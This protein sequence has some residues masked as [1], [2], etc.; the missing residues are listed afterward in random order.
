M[1]SQ[2]TENAIAQVERRRKATSQAT[3]SLGCHQLN[4]RHCSKWEEPPK[5]RNS[6]V[7]FF[8]CTTGGEEQESCLLELLPEHGM[9]DLKLRMP[10]DKESRRSV[11]FGATI[12]TTEIRSEAFVDQIQHLWHSSEELAQIENMNMAT[13]RLIKIGEQ[14]SPED[15]EHCK[16]GLESFLSTKSLAATEATVNEVLDRQIELWS[17]GITGDQSRLLSKTYCLHSCHHVFNA[18]VQGLNDW[19]AVKGSSPSPTSVFHEIYRISAAA[20]GSPA[21]IERQYHLGSS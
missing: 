10:L 8:G 7:R 19:L 21:V 15:M 1:F 14:F 16:R 6:C 3:P 20:V 9:F 17:A 13:V 2:Q 12:V 4:K 5:R 11:T 18:L